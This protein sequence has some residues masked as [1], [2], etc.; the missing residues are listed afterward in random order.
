MTGGE[1]FGCVEAG[2]T[3][4]V[5]AVGSAPDRI[6]A[7]TRIDTTTPK[8]TLERALAF[9][10]AEGLA[11]GKCA[12]FGVASFGPL[13][14]DRRAA[15]WGR[16]GRTPKP[17]WSGTDMAGVF[18]RAVDA[19]VGFNTDVAAAALA[20]A[21]WGAAQGAQLAIYLTV[22]TGIGGG[23]VA[24]GRPF[25]GHTHAEMGHMIPAR[26][27][28]DRD[29][30]GVCPFHGACLEGLASG[31]AIFAR[32]GASLSDLPG[33]HPAHA[34]VGWYLGGHAANLM[35]AIAPDLIVIGGGV[36]ATH[37]LID[38][39]RIAAAVADGGYRA[40]PPAW[41]R[42]IVAPGLGERSGILGALALAQDAARDG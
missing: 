42:I 3:K 38:R 17:G 6:E 7:I 36:L 32:W 40:D 5:C 8:E 29:F 2:G 30:P 4:F 15:D 27:P 16:I 31:P 19:P 22:G 39:I 24:N 26:H 11:P 23:V 28:E 18:G 34:I 13:I 25:H 37:G 10:R 9:F 35:A 20:E 12:G 1:R 21:R 41:Q 33:H 14:L